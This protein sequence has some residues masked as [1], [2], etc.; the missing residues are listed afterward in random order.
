MRPTRDEYHLRAAENAASMATCIRRS[1]GCVLTNAR[2][3]QLSSGYNGV[4][5]GAPHCNQVHEIAMGRIIQYQDKLEI[6]GELTYPYACEGASSPSGTNLEGCDAIHAEQNAL[7]Q[8]PDVFRIHTC[9]VTHS[10]CI[11][12][13]KLLLGTSCQRVVF[14]EKYSH[15]E[16]ARLKWLKSKYNLENVA[17]EWIHLPRTSR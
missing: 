4:E 5:S 16:P 10:P 7:L 2:G 17:R 14:R 1:V 13:V 9:Y 12:C 15:D 8:C 3:H 11:H 6:K